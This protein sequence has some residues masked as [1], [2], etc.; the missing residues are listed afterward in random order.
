MIPHLLHQYFHAADKSPGMYNVLAAP[1]PGERR[2]GSIHTKT[3]NSSH[4]RQPQNC[5]S[6]HRAGSLIARRIAACVAVESLLPGVHA[7]LL[8]RCT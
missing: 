3:F 4:L 6:A 8:Y 7:P 2:G 5:R 1:M